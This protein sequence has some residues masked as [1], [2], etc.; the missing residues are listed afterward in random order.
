MLRRLISLLLLAWALGFVGFALALPQPAGKEHTDGVVVLTGGKGRIDRGL[1]ALRLGWAPKLF[2]SGVDA[3]V[4]PH[5][6]AI[7]YKIGSLQMACCVTL[8][9]AA[10]DTISNARETA[11]WI[12]LQR[13]H[14]VRL[15]TS[16]W[17][18][19]RA[20]LE[21]KRVIPADV[22]IVEDAVPSQPSLKMLFLEYHKLLA[23][24]TV[25]MVRA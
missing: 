25:R 3:E 20:A 7:E 15:V 5:E 12:S 24:M 16:D 6:F 11:G 22:V 10:T 2:V 17:H 23:R 4:K 14:S 21:L 19:R 8:G 18:M 9:F 1:E 13:L